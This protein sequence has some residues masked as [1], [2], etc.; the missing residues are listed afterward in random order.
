MTKER[1]KTKSQTLSVGETAKRLDVSPDSVRN[2]CERGWLQFFRLRGKHR[3]VMLRSI[4]AFEAQRRPNKPDPSRLPEPPPQKRQVDEDFE[5]YYLGNDLYPNELDRGYICNLSFFKDLFPGGF[6]PSTILGDVG[7]IFGGGTFKILRI[8]DGE[9]I[10]E[11]IISVPGP[12]KD[13]VAIMRE[14]YMDL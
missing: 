2:Y 12:T 13:D 1:A 4:E 11:R 7:R 5:I 3:R 6:N 9:V 14:V 10:S 8:R